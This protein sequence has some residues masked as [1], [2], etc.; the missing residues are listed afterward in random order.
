MGSDALRSLCQ[1]GSRMN[2]ATKGR[3]LF[4]LVPKQGRLLLQ[5]LEPGDPATKQEEYEISGGKW[6]EGD[7]EGN[8]MVGMDYH[9][10]FKDARIVGEKLI[11]LQ[12]GGL[13][14]VVD[15]WLTSTQGSGTKASCLASSQDTRWRTGTLG[16]TPS[17]LTKHSKRTSHK[18]SR[19]RRNF[20]LKFCIKN[21]TREARTFYRP[22]T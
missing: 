16:L 18:N 12:V 14:T 6:K 20:P 3:G 4:R 11:F 19:G 9:E 17:F 5:I 13:E 1:G 7:L 2:F 8:E 21:F 15:G 10:V 22:S